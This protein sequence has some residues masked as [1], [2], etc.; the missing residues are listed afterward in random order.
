MFSKSLVRTIALAAAV[1]LA[2]PLF[3]KPITKTIN[4]TQPAKFGKAELKAGEYTLLI[5]G[6]KVTVKRGKDVVA[7]TE[8]R[9]EERDAK[10]AYNSVLIGPDGAV[11][12]VRFSGNRSVLVLAE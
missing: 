6:S 9:W 5:D 3:A 8:G 2:V 1:A 12:E 7:E 10:T 11:K 4:I